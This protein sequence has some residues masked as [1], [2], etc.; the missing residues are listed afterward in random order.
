MEACTPVL[1]QVKADRLLQERKNAIDA[2]Y[3]VFIELFKVYASSVPPKER[4]YIP[5]LTPTFK[6]DYILD[7]IYAEG[8]EGLTEERI[9]VIREELGAKL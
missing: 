4:I 7:V 2:R 5:V 6:F 1:D 3:S 8:N 9:G